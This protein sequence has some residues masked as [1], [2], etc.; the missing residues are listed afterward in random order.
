MHFTACDTWFKQRKQVLKVYVAGG[1][2][3][4][5]EPSNGAV[6]NKAGTHGSFNGQISVN[7]F[8]LLASSRIA[9]TSASNL[10]AAEAT[11][12]KLGKY[13]NFSVSFFQ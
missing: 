9:N 4:A 13:D 11:V 7:R 3:F 6:E 1:V 8:F 5:Q 12:T 10:G 2:G